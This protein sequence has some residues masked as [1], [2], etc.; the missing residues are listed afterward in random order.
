MGSAQKISRQVAERAGPG[1]RESCGIEQC[2]VLIEIRINPGNQVR[3][4][5]GARRTTVKCV[6]N[7]CTAGCRRRENSSCGVGIDDVRPS[8]ENIHRKSATSI[9]DAAD[10]P[11]AKDRFGRAGQAAGWNGI[12]EARVEIVAYIELIVAVVDVE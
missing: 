6:D 7:S 8:D 4:P 12:H 3:P 9:G 10:F 2:A 5:C 1:Y 11:V